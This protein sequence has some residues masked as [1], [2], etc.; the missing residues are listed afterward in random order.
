MNLGLVLSYIVAAIITMALL[1]MNMGVQRSTAELTLLNMKK[2]HMTSI[3]EMLE[4][5][6]SKT[7]YE[8]SGP[9]ADAIKVADSTSFA[10]EADIDN[11]GDID[12]V[13]WDFTILPVTGTTNPND[14]ILRRT[15]IN[16]VNN[17]AMIPVNTDITDITLGAID[18][19]FEYFMGTGSGTPLSTPVLTQASR[20]NIAQIQVSLTLES[21]VTISN[22][23]SDAGR[24]VRTHYEKLFSPVNLNN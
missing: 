20:N 17:T 2:N 15:Y 18:M 13:R 14:R 3:T 12:L 9:I 11:D 1:T 16:D 7:A 22:N 4:Y 19:N 21:D 6:I 23:V 10:F 5:D 8:I 24:R